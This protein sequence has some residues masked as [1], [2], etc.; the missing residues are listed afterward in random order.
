MSEIPDT[1]ASAVERTAMI[2][3]DELPLPY[4]EI[5]AG[6]IITRANR[7]ARALQHPRQGELIGMTGWDL[8][9]IDEKEFSS[10]A[11]LSYMVSG[12]DPPVMHRSIFD[13]S[14]RFRTYEFHRSL[15]HDPEGKPAG[16]RMVFVDV[17]ESKKALEDARRDR[18]WLESAM[19]SM[20]LAVILTDILGVVRS[21]NPAAEELSG[22]TA[23]EL[24]G[25]VIEEAMPI[26]AY[27]SLDGV[28]F[29]RREVIER[30]SKG[31]ATLLSRDGK[32]VKVEIGTS[33]ILD[34]DTGAVSGVA[35]ILRKVEGA[36]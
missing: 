10:A 6:G 15:I 29:D 1:L 27:E 20:P 25:K 22:F 35:A 34:K 12:Q 17:T 7:A 30:R 3:I 2:D 11:F 33:P 23:R 21:S 24:T 5:D 26:L 9:A 14:G 13:R 16:M 19:S 28:T 4:V 18:Q 36:S 32:E 31:I 8:M